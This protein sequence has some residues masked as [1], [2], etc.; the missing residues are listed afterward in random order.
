MKYDVFISYSHANMEQ[1]H[2]LAKR[3]VRHRLPHPWWK[4]PWP[5][6]LRVFLDQNEA[7][8]VSLDEDLKKALN[9]SETLLLACSPSARASKY[10]NDEIR[11]FRRN[12]V[13]P[14][15]V[16]VLVAGL[17]ND[18]AERTGQPH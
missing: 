13:E 8:G 16:P 4:L 7:H 12:R 6:K 1:V 11:E 14:H 3:L 17:P 2:R 18:E 15:I 5:P 9:D 10:V